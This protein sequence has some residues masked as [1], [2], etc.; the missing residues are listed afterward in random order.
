MRRSHKYKAYSRLDVGYKFPRR[1][2][3][4]KRPK[5]GPMKDDLKIL[6]MDEENFN[7]IDSDVI[8][9]ETFGWNRVS[10][11]YKSRLEF[12]SSLFANFDQSI[13][14]RRLKSYKTLSRF[15]KYAKHCAE[16]FFKT[17]TLLWASY[18]FKSTYE[19]KQNIDFSKIMVN[20]SL[21]KSNELLSSGS[22]VSVLDKNFN[23][24][25]NLQKYSE[26]T[27]LLSFVEVDYYAQDLVLIKEMNS[28]SE[29]DL[30][31]LVINSLN[32]ST[33]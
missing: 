17:T 6:L 27:Q 13:K 9:G 5:W 15:D 8:V 14:I 23:L 18:F 16:G 26:N 29:D 12:Y 31:L 28:I 33:L 30:N 25:T 24:K 20:G 1:L 22:V 10:R 3:N 7:L 2:L 4:L 32:F 21:A 11:T 19:A